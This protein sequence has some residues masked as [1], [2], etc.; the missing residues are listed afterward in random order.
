M[1]PD[2]ARQTVR[3]PGQ[4]NGDA[5][6]TATAAMNDDNVDD[7][8]V[9]VPGNAIT[10]VDGTAAAAAITSSNTLQRSKTIEILRGRSQWK[11]ISNEGG[12]D[13]LSGCN[14]DNAGAGG[15]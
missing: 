10:V 15:R 11:L 3:R 9:L 4:G 12:S 14:D 1:Y 2:G 6:T 8:T 7:E 13:N 5:D